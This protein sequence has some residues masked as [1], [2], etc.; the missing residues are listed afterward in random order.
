MD[1]PRRRFLKGAG[2]AGTAGVL[3]WA[4][5]AQGQQQ[6]QATPRAAASAGPKPAD[7]VLRNGKVITV[8]A[9]STIAQAIAI[10][11]DRIVAVGPEAAV[12]AATS[13]ATRVID[14]RGKAVIPGLTDGHA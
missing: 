9:A 13:P 4:G 10:A 7:L 2:A 14:L 12:A 5:T 1:D 6:M 3:G 11:G 8:D